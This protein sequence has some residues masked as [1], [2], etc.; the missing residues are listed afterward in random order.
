MTFTSIIGAKNTLKAQRALQKILKKVEKNLPLE[1]SQRPLHLIIDP[2]VKKIAV[3]QTEEEII[4]TSCCEKNLFHGA[5]MLFQ[6]EELTPLHEEASVLTPPLDMR[7]MVDMARKFFTLEALKEMVEVLAFF[8][9]SALQLHF[10]ENEG[11]RIECTSHPE[12]L[13]THY[14]TKAEIRE[15]ILYAESF[16]MEVIP[17]LDSPGHLKKA[18]AHHPEWTLDKLAEDGSLTKDPRALDILNPKAVAFVHDLYAEYAELFNTSRY[19]HLGSDEFVPF[20]DLHLYPT[21]EKTA[22]EKY[23]KESSGIELFIDYVNETCTYLESLGF[24]PVVWNDGFYRVNR[25]EQK[26]LNL[27]AEISYWTRWNKFMAPV[28]TFLE[29]NY[30]LI[31]HNDNFLYYVPG[32]HA[33]Y[34]YPSYEKIKEGFTPQLFASNQE[35][36][37]EKM[38]QVKACVISIWCNDTLAKTEKEI[39]QDLFYLASA[40]N[41]KVLGIDLGPKEKIIPWQTKFFNEEQ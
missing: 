8:Q 24:Q 28:E 11:F 5:L 25:T 1:K 29:K 23:G 9:F 22:L 6:Q 17:D 30:T 33:S 15:L 4:L 31:N 19:F 38:N 40:L 39:N 7:V 14:L 12:V 3:V 37:T 20:D 10:S 26:H 13:S 35:I 41:Q 21:L 2:A 27:K 34:T 32:E 18:L 36:P 16:F